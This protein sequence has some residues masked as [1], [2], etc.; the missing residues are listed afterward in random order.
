MKNDLPHVSLPDSAR[1]QPRLKAIFLS[2]RA[3]KRLLAACIVFV[4]VLLLGGIYILTNG[5]EQAPSKNTANTTTP[6]AQP[7][8]P[9]PVA[10]PVV[11]NFDFNTHIWA[12]SGTPPQC[13]SPIFKQSP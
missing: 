5:S 13:P 9:K 3:D 12:A 10:V 1:S 2:I 4:V 11:W 8:K 6:P 7:P